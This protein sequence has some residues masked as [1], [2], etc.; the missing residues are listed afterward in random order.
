MCDMPNIFERLAVLPKNTLQPYITHIRFPFYKNLVT[1]ARINFDYPLTAI[2]GM[3]GSSKSSI[4]RAIYGAP[5]KKSISEYWF[6]SN[7]DTIKDGNTEGEKDKTRPSSFIYGYWNSFVNKNVEV[8][9]TRVRTKNR[10]VDYWEPAK[11]QSQYGMEKMPSLRD[12]PK[13]FGRSAT[14]WNALEKNVIYL[15]F[16]HKAISA[17]DRYFYNGEF[18]E[19]NK[20]INSKQDF[21]RERSK[22][23]QNIIQNNIQTKVWHKVERINSNI[24]VPDDQKTEICKI[25]GKNY[26]QIRIIEHK[27]FTDTFE[28]TI[29]VSCEDL[30]YSEAFAG[31]GEFAVISLVTAVMT[32]PE[33]SLILLDEPEVSVHPGA[34][35]KLLEFLAEQILKKKHQIVFTT[36]S[37]SMLQSLPKEAIHV[38]YEDH[39]NKIDVRSNVASSEA[40]S[41]IGAKFDKKT[42]IVEDI[43]AKLLVEHILKAHNILDQ[44]DVKASPNGAEWIKARS[45]VDG[46]LYQ[47]NNVMYILDGDKKHTHVD[48]ET[49]PP[50]ENNSL[51]VKIKQ[52]TGCEIQIPHI[53]GNIEDKINKQRQFLKYYKE[54][55][56]YFPTN[57]PEDIIWD[58]VPETEKAGINVQDSKEAF[59]ILTRRDIGENKADDILYTQR[60]FINKINATTD[61][62][63]RAIYDNIVQTLL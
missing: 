11:P 51:S 38:L 46:A 7:I 21:I 40:F 24:I 6:E 47:Q 53:A 36:H 54:K 3:N 32:A 62:H 9:K 49:I 58:A 28:K 48:P 60:R 18:K 42:I 57:D 17:F 12:V 13:D 14:R 2:V 27:F 1:D 50:A 52:Q 16:R 8:L 59:A 45:I 23:L 37:Q 61:L 5:A 20:K 30:R 56:F 33:K 15:D 10:S 19:K 25:L 43:V 39:N 26:T 35:E 29:Y 41:V 44:V 34:Q 55:V 22:Y 4:L 31:S 63:C